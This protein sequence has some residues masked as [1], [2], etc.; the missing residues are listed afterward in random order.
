MWCKGKQ[1]D[2]AEETIAV[3]NQVS[4]EPTSGSVSVS[5]TDLIQGFCHRAWNYVSVTLHLCLVGDSEQERMTGRAIS[6]REQSSLS[7]GEAMSKSVFS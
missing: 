1:A 6:R 5:M 2:S 4:F 3:Y 7:K